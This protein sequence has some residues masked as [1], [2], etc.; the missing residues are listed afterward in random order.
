MDDRLSIRV[1]NRSVYHVWDTDMDSKLRRCKFFIYENARYPTR[2]SKIF[3]TYTNA[4][5]SFQHDGI[6]YV[7]VTST[8]SRIVCKLFQQ[9]NTSDVWINLIKRLKRL[10][11]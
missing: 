9:P 4:F 6:A 10:K 11:F 8:F 1:R 7:I 5:Q 2:N 3:S